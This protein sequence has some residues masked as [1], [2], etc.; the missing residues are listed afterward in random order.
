M[1]LLVRD[2]ADI[3]RENIEF[4]LSQGVDY[5]VAIDNGSQDG[6]RDI[7]NEYERL[8][9]LH[10]LDEKGRDYAQSKWVTKAAL[11]AREEFGADWILNND[12]DEFWCPSGGNFKAVLQDRTAAILKCQRF[13]MIQAYDGPEDTPW[14]ERLTYRAAQPVTPPKLDDWYSSPLPCPYFYLDLPPKALVRAKKLTK[15]TQGN[16]DARFSGWIRKIRT[17]DR[18]TIFHFPFRSREQF[19]RKIVNG[20]QAYMAN[21]ELTEASGWHWRRWYRLIVEQGLDA[22]LADALPSQEELREHLRAGR[23]LEDAR[24]RE[25]RNT[26]APLSAAQGAAP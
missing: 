6:T 10:L 12:A 8:G 3:V 14:F 23:A 11:L 17:E 4:H 7:L 26:I 5:I 9:V 19:E 18:I 15:V 2:E 16:H 25:L 22:A 24:F 20:G 13:N 1:T 21:L